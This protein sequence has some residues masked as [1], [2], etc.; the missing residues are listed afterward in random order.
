MPWGPVTGCRSGGGSA[1]VSWAWTLIRCRFAGCGRIH[2]S[3]AV[4]RLLEGHAALGPGP[5][6][7]WRGGQWALRAVP[8]A[9]PAPVVPGDAAAGAIWAATARLSVLAA[10]PGRARRPEP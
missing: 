2:R 1:S 4:R 9:G 7:K 3:P 8:V 10:A 5:C 6:A